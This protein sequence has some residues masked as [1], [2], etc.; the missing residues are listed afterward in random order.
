MDPAGRVL[1]VKS[2]LRSGWEY[3]AGGAEAG[4]L[5]E[6]ACRREV[7]EE[8]G[9]KLGDLT[10]LGE[11]PSPSGH[12]FY[13]YL[14]LISH[15]EAVRLRRDPFEISAVRWVGLEEAGSLWAPHIQERLSGYDHILEREAARLRCEDGEVPGPGVEPAV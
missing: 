15:Q 13:T 7:R 4:E 2:R 8:T 5:P 9:L 1:L 6:E 12:P 14:A 11:W 3:P 10:F